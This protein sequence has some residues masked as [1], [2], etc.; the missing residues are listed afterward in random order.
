MR[1]RAVTNGRGG[2]FDTRSSSSGK[3][4]LGGYQADGH[5]AADHG[6]CAL[7]IVSSLVCA[8]AVRQVDVPASRGLKAEA[9]AVGPTALS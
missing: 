4:R 2:Q 8:I 6:I 5:Q 3:G 1:E 7:H 9:P